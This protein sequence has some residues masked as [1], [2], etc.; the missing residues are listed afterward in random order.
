ML[1]SVQPAISRY[2]SE[3]IGGVYARQEFYGYNCRSIRANPSNTKNPMN[4]ILVAEPIY[5]AMPP[6]VYFNRI[7]FW[8]D[9]YGDEE[10]GFYKTNPMI[11]GPR[12]NIRS[13]RDLAIRKALE[14]K[15]THVFFMDDDILVPPQILGVLLRLDKPIVGGL[16]HKDDGTPIVFYDRMPERLYEPDC[17]ELPWLYHPREGAFECAAVAAGCMLIQSEVLHNLLE[18]DRWAF[19]YDETE[20][21][22]D[23]RFCR[24][25]RKAGFS[26]WCWPDVP[27]QQIRHY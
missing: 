13:A 14:M 11:L 24:K 10:Q 1:P 15:A 19:T 22:M 27:C 23:V 4:K 16:I 5:H 26:V 3:K 7:A 12:R 8:K 6:Q 2:F 21:S 9:V 17:G 18:T 20:R 25:A